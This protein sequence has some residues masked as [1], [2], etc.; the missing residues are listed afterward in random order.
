MIDPDGTGGG[1]VISDGPE[2][3]PDEGYTWTTY[4]EQLQ[5]AGVSWRNYQQADNGEHNPLIWFKNFEQ[6]PAGSPLYQRGVAAV[7][8]VIQA[9][10]DDVR[11]DNLPQVSWIIGPYGTCEHPSQLPAAGAVF[12]SELLE[13]LASNPRVWSKTAFFVTYDENGGFFDHVP[14]PVP[15]AGTAAEF[16]EGLPIGLGFRVPGIM[17]SPLSIG[18]G[19]CSQVFD[20]TS[21]L[22]FLEEVFGVE[23]KNI[24]QWRR[25]TC[26]DLTTTLNIARRPAASFP[27]LPPTQGSLLEQYV[28]SQ[29]G[30][31]SAPVV[32]AEQQFPF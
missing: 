11:S 20:H 2:S 16:V 29:D 8:N 5:A 19:V 15:P 31:Y 1:P 9:F 17:V 23:A 25:Q 12:I 13:T 30:Y 3:T 32:P 4:A 21:I 22:R 6:A 27:S 24:S 18:G 14:P 10:G 28:T 26:G 7:D